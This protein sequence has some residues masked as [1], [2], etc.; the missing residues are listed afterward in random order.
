MILTTES[1]SV[2][3]FD[4]HNNRIRRLS[5]EHAPTDRQ[6]KDGEWKTY[7]DLLCPVRVG[8]PL[9]IVWNYDN[10]VAKSTA[11]SVVISIEE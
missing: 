5:G 4:P 6:P 8:N 11:T 3:E 10:G 2:Y 9:I 1:K 7:Q